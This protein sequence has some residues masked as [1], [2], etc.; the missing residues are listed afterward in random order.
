MNTLQHHHHHTHTTTTTTHYANP[1]TTNTT[2][3]SATTTTNPPTRDPQPSPLKTPSELMECYD[4]W[5]PTYDHDSL[6]FFGYKAP[7][8]AAE[9]LS[10]GELGAICWG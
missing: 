1:T 6:S 10:A 5:A 4:E 7:S 9:V 8:R 2:P 3:T